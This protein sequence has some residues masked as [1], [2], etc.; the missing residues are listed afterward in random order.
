MD[1][2]MNFKLDSHP[3]ARNANEEQRQ[4]LSKTEKVCADVCAATGSPIALGAVIIIQII[5]VLI[6][7]LTNIDP[8][9][10]AFMLTVSNVIQ[11]ILIFVLAV[12]QRQATRHS[13]IMVETDHASISHLLHHQDL[14]EKMLARL[15]ER[16]H[17]DDPE[18]KQ[19]LK[20]LAP[21]E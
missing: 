2:I 8:F 6:G 17:I 15:L 7:Q 9:P 5:W 4:Q 21:N 12:G 16:S 20:I 18:I 14:Q 10:F 1:Q 19:Q 3:L 13:E 11:L